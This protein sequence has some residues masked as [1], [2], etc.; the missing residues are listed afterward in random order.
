MFLRSLGF[1]LVKPFLA[2]VWDGPFLTSFGI[3]AFSKSCWKNFFSGCLLRAVQE[4]I[5]N[6]MPT[7]FMDLI[8]TP[9]KDKNN[10]FSSQ[11]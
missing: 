5:S 9:L 7:N 3:L 8:Q 2:T 6:A 1:F 4:Q 10:P 11:R